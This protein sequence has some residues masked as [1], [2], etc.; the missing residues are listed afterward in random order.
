MQNRTLDRSQS[1]KDD[2][3]KEVGDVVLDP[4]RWLRTPNDRL[5]GREPMDLIESDEASDQERVRDLI[6]AIKHGLFT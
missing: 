3:I 6:E 4:D 5:G 1:Q 2:L